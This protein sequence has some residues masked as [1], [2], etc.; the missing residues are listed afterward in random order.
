MFVVT[1]IVQICR[2][3]TFEKDINLKEANGMHFREFTETYP[4]LWD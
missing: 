3:S 1:L 2:R 4:G